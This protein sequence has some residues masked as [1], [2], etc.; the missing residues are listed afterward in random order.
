[1]KI[2]L[3]IFNPGLTL[4]KIK[5]LN[6]FLWILVVKEW[7]DICHQAIFYQNTDVWRE[8]PT[9]DGKCLKSLTFFTTFLKIRGCKSLYIYVYSWV[10]WANL[11]LTLIDRGFQKD[12][13]SLIRIVVKDTSNSQDAKLDTDFSTEM[14]FLQ[15]SGL[16]K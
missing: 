11:I 5:L 4:P 15:D 14:K 12:C 3:L 6:G 16:Q 7:I 9:R 10:D 13:S 8:G 2:P 1:M